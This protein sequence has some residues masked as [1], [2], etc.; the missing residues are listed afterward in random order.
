[1]YKS[2]V[3]FGRKEVSGDKMKSKLVPLPIARENHMPIFEDRVELSRN[4]SR[5]FLPS[6][7][8]EQ[9]IGKPSQ[10][11]DNAVERLIKQGYKVVGTHSVV[12]L[13]GWTKSAVKEKGTCYKHKFYGIESHRCLQMSS[14]VSC[15]NRCT[16]CWR[17]YKAPVAKDWPWKCEDAK[18]IFDAVINAQKLLF[19]GYNKRD[20][21]DQIKVDEGFAPKH[22]ALSLTGEPIA[23]PKIN[24]L[25]ELFHEA[26]MSTFLVTNAQFPESIEQLIPVTQLYL[27]IDAPNKERLKEIDKPLFAD[28]WERMLQCLDLLKKRKERTVIRLTMVKTIN[29]YDWKNY[30]EL[31]KRGD[32]DF[33]EVKGYM[34]I[35]A[36]RERLSRD[37]MPTWVEIQEYS[38]LLLQYLEDYELVE[39]QKESF[40]ILLA[41]KA[42]KSNTKIDFDTL[43]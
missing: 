21:I 11:S 32:P 37:C 10:L 27:S 8:S 13:C 22:V 24:D 41:K 35:G 26:K 40:V 28:Y 12:K 38:Q 5:I 30:A 18:E 16:F 9:N 17:D 4:H 39:G 34:H 14:S 7:N 6:T 43:F 1:M 36:S 31:I 42:F 15:A 29:T 2:C 20:D 23:Y 33:V 3:F 25:I 19:T